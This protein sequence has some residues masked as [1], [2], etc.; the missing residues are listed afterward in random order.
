MGSLQTW[1]FSDDIV[2]GLFD[3]IDLGG[4]FR[5]NVRMRREFAA[6]EPSFL[7]ELYNA[8]PGCT[9]RWR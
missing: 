6:A 5:M 7:I 2:P 3:F 9:V 1:N 4:V 8:G